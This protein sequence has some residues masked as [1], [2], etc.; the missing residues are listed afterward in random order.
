[1]DRVSSCQLLWAQRRCC[2]MNVL[3]WGPGSPGIPLGPGWPLTPL[4]PC[5]DNM[6][7]MTLVT[8]SQ[9]DYH[10]VSDLIAHLWTWSTWGAR[11]S[12]SSWL[13]RWTLQEHTHRDTHTVSAG[14]LSDDWCITS[15]RAPLLPSHRAILFFHPVPE[16]KQTLN[17]SCVR[18]CDVRITLIIS[19][20]KDVL[21]HS[22][23]TA[24]VVAGIEHR[25]RTHNIIIII[26]VRVSSS[27]YPLITGGIYSVRVVYYLN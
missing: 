22:D 12:W 19:H 2:I 7:S 17:D 8:I 21:V 23:R 11:E 18:Q 6:D 27:C 13:S 1:M 26:S 24:E 3:T 10:N 5:R 15:S 16:S 14:C 9:N 20:I 25:W 4:A